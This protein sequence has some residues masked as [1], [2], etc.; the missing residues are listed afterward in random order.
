LVHWQFFKACLVAY[1]TTKMLLHLLIKLC[2]VLI[3]FL[4][5]IKFQALVNVVELLDWALD[6][7]HFFQLFNGDVV[8]P[9]VFKFISQN[10]IDFFKNL[11]ELRFHAFSHVVVIVLSACVV[12]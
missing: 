4:S 7:L 2:I 3:D 10:G 8:R 5:Q 6:P 12:I 9:L 11:G 1:R